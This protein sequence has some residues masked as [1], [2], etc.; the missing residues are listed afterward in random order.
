MPPRE[1]LVRADDDGVRRRIGLEH[2]QRR[3]RGHANA[4]SLP[5]REPPEAVVV[6]ERLAVL[7]NDVPGAGLEPVAREERAIVVTG[8]E[9]RLLALGAL[10]DRETGTRRLGTR[11]VLVLLAEGKPDALELL[12]VEPREHVRLILCV[13][14]AAVQEQTSTMLRDPRV[15]AGR[16]PIAAGTPR[17]GE[18]LC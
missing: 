2:V 1:R 11:R 5:G 18:Q 14:R 6:A 3:R 4:L 7:V 16:E 9:A 10:R 17:E 13:I 8:K 12:W 15:V